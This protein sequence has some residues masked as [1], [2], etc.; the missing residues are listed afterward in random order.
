LELLSSESRI[1]QA[2]SR[3]IEALRKRFEFFRRRVASLGR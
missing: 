3:V 1:T 2:S